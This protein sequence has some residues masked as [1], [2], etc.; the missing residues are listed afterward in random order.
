MKA[1]LASALMVTLSAC[2][3]PQTTVRTGSA[4]PSLVVTGAPSG[5]VLYVDGLPMGSAP[6][7]DGRP[8][9]LAVLEGPHQVEVRD[10]SR[11]LYKGKVFVSSGETHTIAILPGAAPSDCLPYSCSSSGSH[12]SF[13]P[14]RPR[15]ATP[16]APTRSPCMSTIRSRL[17]RAILRRAWRPRS[18]VLR[19]PGP[20]SRRVCTPSTATSYCKMAIGM[21][22]WLHSERRDAMDRIQTLH[23]PHDPSRLLAAGH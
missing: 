4:Q 13:L 16:G 5:A 17:P 12:Q 9:T 8:R 20:S 6:Q 14:V 22:Q 3:L 18:M 11:A 2:A 7:Y 23:G 19:A 1:L 15:A 21:A 10:G